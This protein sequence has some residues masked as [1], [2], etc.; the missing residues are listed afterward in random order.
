M[1]RLRPVVAVPAVAAACVDSP[2][3]PPGE[4]QDTG[5]FALPIAG[6]P[7]R[8]WYMTNYVDGQ[9]RIPA[10]ALDEPGTWSAQIETQEGLAATMNFTVTVA[11]AVRVAPDADMSAGG[12]GIR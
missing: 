10:T 6:E 9:E 2:S 8:D 7:N 11:G 1:R 12:G 3:S 4:E 5:L